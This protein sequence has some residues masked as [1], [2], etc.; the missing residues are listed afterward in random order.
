MDFT[1][2]AQ[3]I[4]RNVEQ[5]VIGKASVTEL[6]LVALL[7]EGHFR[8]GLPLARLVE[9]ISANPARVMGLAPRKGAILPGADADLAVVDL[10]APWVVG[11]ESL[12]TDAGYSIYEGEEMACRVTHTLSRGRF[13]LRDGA[14]QDGAIGQGRFVPR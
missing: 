14:L 12:A 3:A 1:Q 7:T 8:R 13:V 5:V 2:F 11:K 10:G 9:L 4:Q 6:L